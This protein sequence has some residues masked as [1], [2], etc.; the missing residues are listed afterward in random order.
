MNIVETAI[1]EAHRFRLQID[2]ACPVRR[3]VWNRNLAIVDTKFIA[4]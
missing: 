1:N 2:N 3:Y 4:V